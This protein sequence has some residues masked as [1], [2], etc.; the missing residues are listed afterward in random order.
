MEK[1]SRKT[2]KRQQ[3]LCPHLHEAALQRLRDSPS[4]VYHTSFKGFRH[5]SAVTPDSFSVL[6]Y[7][8]YESDL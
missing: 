6:F 2:R 1:S 3:F 8:C 7:F 4:A 5:D